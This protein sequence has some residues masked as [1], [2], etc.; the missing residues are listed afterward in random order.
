[1]LRSR[2]RTTVSEASISTG[3]SVQ[4]VLVQYVILNSHVSTCHPT[5]AVCISIC[6]DWSLKSLSLP[7][8]SDRYSFRQTDLA[9]KCRLT[10]IKYITTLCS[11]YIHA[12]AFFL[13]ESRSGLLL[14]NGSPAELQA[15]DALRN[16]SADSYQVSIL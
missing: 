13:V 14:M 8:R 6:E 1:M 7:S 9:W 4:N 3:R 15:Y 16:Y 12:N 5:A 2:P 10:G 11:Y